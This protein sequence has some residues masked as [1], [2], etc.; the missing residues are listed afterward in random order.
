MYNSRWLRISSE[1][2]TEP[3]ISATFAET[4][5]LSAYLIA[6]SGGER[7]TPKIWG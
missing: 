5:I 7:E 2:S 1:I 6:N 4:R 3:P